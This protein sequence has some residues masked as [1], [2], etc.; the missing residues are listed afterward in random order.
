MKAAITIDWNVRMLFIFGLSRE[1]VKVI[2][3]REGIKNKHCPIRLAR[4]GKPDTHFDWPIR[5]EP[6]SIKNGLARRVVRYP[7]VRSL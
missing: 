1:D 6:E 7:L 3:N 5:S 2:M 4:S